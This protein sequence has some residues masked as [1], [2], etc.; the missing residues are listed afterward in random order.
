MPTGKVGFDNMY[1]FLQ[2]NCT[3]AWI[4]TCCVKKQLMYRQP[5]LREME[6]GGQ[7]REG[8]EGNYCKRGRGNNILQNH[9]ICEIVFFQMFVWICMKVCSC[10]WTKS[11]MN[12]ILLRIL[13]IQKITSDERTSYCNQH[14][15]YCTLKRQIIL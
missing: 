9:K 7:Q 10:L 14:K 8:E 2:N 3:L 4:K 11:V 13:I 6:R 5:E 15:N 1:A 12:S